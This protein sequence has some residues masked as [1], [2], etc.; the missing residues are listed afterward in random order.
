M[1]PGTKLKSM[2]NTLPSPTGTPCSRAHPLLGPNPKKGFFLPP[3]ASLHSIL[4]HFHVTGESHLHICSCTH[5]HSHFPQRTFPPH[6]TEMPERS[7]SKAQSLWV[8]DEPEQQR[9]RAHSMLPRASQP[10]YI[11]LQ[12]AFCK[13]IL[14]HRAAF[15]CHCWTPA[16]AACTSIQPTESKAAPWDKPPLCYTA[17]P[18]PDTNLKFASS[19][20]LNPNVLPT[21]CTLVLHLLSESDLRI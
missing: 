8:S 21:L 13:F 11:Q 9:P 4:C 6:G 18:K 14:Q 5:S 7:H 10:H 1:A 20:Y 12:A 16:A 15:I 17:S 19:L 3:L 2:Q